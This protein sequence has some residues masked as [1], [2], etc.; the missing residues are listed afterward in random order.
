VK[1]LKECTRILQAH[2]SGHPIS[3]SEGCIIGLE[4][5]LPTIIPFALRQ[6]ILSGVEDDIRGVLSL[7]QAYRVIKVPGVLK[8]STITDPFKGQSS[9]LGK[10]ELIRAVKELGK[11][12]ELKPITL[13]LLT[14]AG[15]NHS[16]S[17]LGV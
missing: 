7:L 10:Y 9:T 2:I 6:R 17:M 3:L 4:K 11:L 15:P 14:S 1:Y 16:T 12:P 13:K 8:L 5:G